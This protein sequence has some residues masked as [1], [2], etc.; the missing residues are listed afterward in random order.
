MP[1]QTCHVRKLKLPERACRHIG[2]GRVVQDERFELIKSK[3]LDGTIDPILV[4]GYTIIDGYFRVRVARHLNIHRLPC[5]F[6]QSEAEGKPNERRND[7]K[8]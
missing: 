4:K 6:I 1:D 3:I 8:R 5:K 7:T 2:E